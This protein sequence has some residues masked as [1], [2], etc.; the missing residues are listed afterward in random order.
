MGK[1]VKLLDKFIRGV[2]FP[3]ENLTRM[4]LV[5]ICGDKRVLIEN[6]GGVIQYNTENIVIRVRY[7]TIIVAG[8]ALKLCHMSS[9]KLIVSGKIHAVVLERGNIC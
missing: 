6:H 3:D 8:V 4:P 1:S 5:E 2:D 9:N 7:G